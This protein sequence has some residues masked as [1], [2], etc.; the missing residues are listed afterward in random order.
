MFG[1]FLTLHMRRLI[2]NHFARVTVKVTWSSF[3]LNGTIR[4]HA[5]KYDYDSKFVRK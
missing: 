2:C 1:H 4:E 3:L 5:S